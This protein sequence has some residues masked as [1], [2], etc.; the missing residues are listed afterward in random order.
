VR[1]ADGVSLE[2]AG[3][4]R[5]GIWGPNGSGKSTLLNL[6]GGQLVADRGTIHLRGQRIDRLRPDERARRGLLRTFQQARVFEAQSV[7]ENLRAGLVAATPL[8]LLKP[9]DR[10]YCDELCKLALRATGVPERTWSDSAG[11]L[12]TGQRKRLE[13]ARVLVCPQASLL[14]LD[15]PTAGLDRHGIPLLI[16]LLD[17]I[18]AEVGVAMIVVD[19]DIP[20]VAATSERIIAMQAGAIRGQVDSGRIDVDAALSGQLE[21]E[22]VS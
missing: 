11:T 1:A 14:L 19:H 3:G 7:V 13:L 16:E 18:A 15:E 21:L 2:L 9:A 12:S 5:V 22:G 4:E 8:R 17:T 6:I 10:A 20:F